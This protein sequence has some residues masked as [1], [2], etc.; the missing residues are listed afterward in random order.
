MSRSKVWK[1]EKQEDFVNGEKARILTGYQV[2]VKVN[3]KCSFLC[4]KFSYSH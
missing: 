1:T 3:I 2:K 4:V